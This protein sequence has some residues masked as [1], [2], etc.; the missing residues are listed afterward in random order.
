MMTYSYSANWFF[1]FIF[2]HKILVVALN[3]RTDHSK[4]QTNELPTHAFF[5]RGKLPKRNQMKYDGIPLIWC[6]WIDSTKYLTFRSSNTWKWV[7]ADFLDAPDIVWHC[8]GERFEILLQN[9][10]SFQKMA[11]LLLWKVQAK[12][13]FHREWFQLS[14][15]YPIMMIFF[16]IYQ[17]NLRCMK[18]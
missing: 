8:P 3:S 5:A 2:F 18:M 13:F 14:T 4:T 9:L 7:L 15:V 16:L 10:E 12:W 6:I 17:I 1:V 11:T